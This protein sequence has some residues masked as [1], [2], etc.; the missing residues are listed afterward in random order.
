MAKIL[1]VEDEIALLDLYEEVLKDADFDVKKCCNGRDALS[2][3][4]KGKYDLVLLDL[5]MPEVDGIEVLKN[6][7]SDPDKYGTPKIV[8]L[9][10]LSSDVTIK[11]SFDSKADGYLMKTELTPNQ[12]VEEVKSFL[13]K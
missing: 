9:T 6:V 2:F 13:I 11:E 7:R 12:I 5:M 1:I 3:L 4:S 10:N 8:I